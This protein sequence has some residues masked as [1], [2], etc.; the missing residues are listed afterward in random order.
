MVTVLPAT[1]T[2]ATTQQLAPFLAQ[3]V[4]WSLDAPNRSADDVLADPELAKYVSGWGRE[5]DLAVLAYDDGHAADASPIGAAWLRRFRVEDAGH[6]FIAADIP[7]LAVAVNREQQGKG[8][9]TRLVRTL[10][11]MARLSGESGVSLSVQ[12]TNGA[13]VM[14]DRLGFEEIG[15]TDGAAIMLKRF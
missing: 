3:A 1:Q 2:S 15:V 14:Y 8:T 9:G 10:L 13:I 4:S 12:Q 5:G 7:E 11:D 6:G